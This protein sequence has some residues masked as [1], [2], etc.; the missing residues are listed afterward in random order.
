MAPSGKTAVDAVG[1]DRR[2]ASKHCVKR[3][4]MTLSSLKTS[5]AIDTDTLMIFGVHATVAR[6]HDSQILLP[7]FD[8][9]SDTFSVDVVAAD[10]G[11]DS[12]HIRH[13][14]KQSGIRPL[15]RHREFTALDKAHNTRMNTDDYNQR[16]MSETVNS[17]VKRP[18]TDT[19]H[20][21]TSWRHARELLLMAF[22]YNIERVTTESDALR[23]HELH[24]NSLHHI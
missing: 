9:V 19:L 21:K 16:A 10:K 2:H 12:T 5:F 8:D 24:S 22:T 4:K 7:L 23:V 11:Y 13:T 6:R 17:M 14:L 18:Y 20:A 1:F 3:A 15:I